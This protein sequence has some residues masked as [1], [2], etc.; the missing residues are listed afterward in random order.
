MGQQDVGASRILPAAHL[1]ASSLRLVYIVCGFVFSPRMLSCLVF[2]YV[3]LP[4]VFLSSRDLF[5]PLLVSS[6]LLYCLASSCLALIGLALPCL[7]WLDAVL[8]FLLF[9]ALVLSCLAVP[10][11]DILISVAL[12]YSHLL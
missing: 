8:D 11:L 1:H 2:P 7:L 12:V 10:C 3:P 9:S 6:L 4:S 5:S